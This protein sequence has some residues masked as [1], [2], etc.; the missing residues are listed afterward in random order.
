M[1]TND[2]DDP[3]PASVLACVPSAI[4]SSERAA[5]FALVGRLFGS[6]VRERRRLDDGYAFR[7][8]ADAFDDVACWVANE[9]RCCPF[10]AFSLELAPDGGALWV[11]LTGPEGTAAFLDAELPA[12]ADTTSR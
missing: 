2:H 9:R 6:A 7:F 10:L 3:R 8:D 11:K 5:H 1:N 4:P 12:L